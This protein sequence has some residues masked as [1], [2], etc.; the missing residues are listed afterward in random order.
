M[1]PKNID[2]KKDNLS[3]QAFGKRLYADQ[4]VYE[5]LLE[6]LLIFSSTKEK[7]GEDTTEYKGEFQF[8]EQL[9]D[10]S[11]YV[12]PRIGLKRFIFFDKSKKQDRFEID[13]ENYQN[14]FTM[15]E[16][17]IRGTEQKDVMVE[18]LQNA[19]YGFSAVLKN[20]SWFAQSL[21]PIA[22]ELIFNE[23][24]GAKSKRGNLHKKDNISDGKE[25]TLNK[26]EK[27]FDFTKH[28][29]MA[30]GGEVY[31]LHILQGLQKRPELKQRLE[32]Y[33]KCLVYTVEPLGKLGAFIQEK[34]EVQEDIQLKEQMQR[35]TCDYIPKGYEK[36]S[37]Y[38][39]QE[40]VNFLSTSI[41]ALDKME[42][43][44][45][46]MMLQIFRMMY[47]QAQKRAKRNEQKPLWLIDVSEGNKTIRNLAQQ[48]LDVYKETIEAANN[49]GL[50]NIQYIG[51]KY[52]NKN[53]SEK[54]LEL[55]LIKD[56]QKHTT[57]LIN[58]IGKEIKLLM[59]ISG[60]KARMTLSEELIT[61][62]VTALLEP[63]QK[64]T[65]DTFYDLLFEHFGIVIGTRYEQKYYTFL[66]IKQNY[67]MDFKENEKGF[68][69]LLKDC[70][71]LRELS[72][73]T[74]IV[75]NPYERDGV[76]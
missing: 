25:Y 50:E 8:H 63:M 71:F 26:T 22:P 35:Y 75:E 41:N 69:R 4:T 44:G 21:L 48:S 64:V 34:W 14:I 12:N 32:K 23:S 65:I 27:M 10:I 31:Y 2:N 73:A 45:P 57:A 60:S 19:F 47:E 17:S 9:D 67:E 62:L 5:Y 29:F 51:E 6:F 39:C 36:R 59:P 30:R 53:Y 43:L 37:E 54:E 3:I 40:L 7:T 11:Y 49:V 70:G 20:R 33:L 52:K 38:T 42:Y 28:S 61:F 46:G 13:K 18:V 72:D 58:K 66:G 16:E 15:V 68:L 56:A 24:M 55:K 74:A 76:S 1:F